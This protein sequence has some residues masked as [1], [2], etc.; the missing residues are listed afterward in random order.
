L[1]RFWGWARGGLNNLKHTIT[2]SSLR[3]M[4]RLE[5]VVNVRTVGLVLRQMEDFIIERKV[6]QVRSV[7]ENQMFRAFLEEM[8]FYQT[9][10]WEK[11]HIAARVESKKNDMK[12]N[13]E[14][15]NITRLLQTHLSMEVTLPTRLVH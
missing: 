7:F 10:Y 1:E 6:D 5:V 15:E 3:K 14:R 12:I 4:E 2:I 11:N 9:S 8:I 13:T